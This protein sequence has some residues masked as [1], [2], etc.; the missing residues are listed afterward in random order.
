MVPVS[1]VL[2]PAIKK[3]LT[4]TFFLKFIFS[5][6]RAVNVFLSLFS[7]FWIDY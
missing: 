5:I 7:L 6:M 2:N 3:Q 4:L 1:L